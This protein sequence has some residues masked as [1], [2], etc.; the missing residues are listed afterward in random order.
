MD[1]HYQDLGEDLRELRVDADDDEGGEVFKGG[2]FSKEEAEETDEIFLVMLSAS[3][4]STTDLF[5]P[6]CLSLHWDLLP[7]SIESRG[8]PGMH[9]WLSIPSLIL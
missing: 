2:C 3:D 8:T 7:V 6:F 1:C 9:T 4:R 5:S